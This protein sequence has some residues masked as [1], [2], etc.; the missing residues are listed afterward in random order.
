MIIN[1]LARNQNHIRVCLT[2]NCS[3][4][5]IWCGVA[6]VSNSTCYLVLKLID[7]TTLCKAKIR[8]NGQVCP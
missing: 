2:S 8:I 1:S 4:L 3:A 7:F 5:I 6:Y